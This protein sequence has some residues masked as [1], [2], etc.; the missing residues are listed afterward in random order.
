MPISGSPALVPYL[1]QITADNTVLLAND[2]EVSWATNTTYTKKKECCVGVFGI[3]C[4]KFDLKINAG[5]NTAYGK[6]YVN[7]I[8]VGTE[9]STQ[10]TAY[11][12]F[13]ENLFIKANDLVQLY[14]QRSAGTSYAQNFRMCG[15]IAPG[16]GVIVLA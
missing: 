15:A 16:V 10:S 9:R 5:A 2:A 14:I 6:I 3:Y 12:T 1:A 13:T 8:A 7:G 11:V 4:V